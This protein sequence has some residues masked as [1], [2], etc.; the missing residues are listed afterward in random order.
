[1]LRTEKIKHSP[2]CTKHIKA[3]TNIVRNMLRAGGGGGVKKIKHSPACTKHIKTKANLVR[4][5]LLA[6][7]WV[8]TTQQY[9]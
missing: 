6:V 5:V 1:M 3:Q 4:I 7:L 9:S 8:K 2:A